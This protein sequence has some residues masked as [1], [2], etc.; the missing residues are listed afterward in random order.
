MRALLDIARVAAGALALSILS[1]AA[2]AQDRLFAGYAID[3]EGLH[4]GAFEAQLVTEPGR[5]QLS[6]AT[7]TEGLIGWLFPFV[8]EGW[9]RGT[10]TAGEIVPEHFQ[11]DSAWRDRTR[12]WAVAFDGDGQVVEI[13]VPEEDLQDRDPVPP[14]LQVAPDPL[15]LALD[16]IIS[17]A[18]GVQRTGT[19]FDGRRAIRFALDCAPTMEGFHDV[20]AGAAAAAEGEALACTVAGEL[21]AG[22]SR[23][24]RDRGDEEREPATVWLRGGILEGSLW[25]VRVVAETRYGTVTAQLVQ[26]ESGDPPP[27]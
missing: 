2:H 18:P 12:T 22:A 14:A 25:P 7:R 20:P 4:I 6:Y 19:S 26:L 23:R 3:W 8:A 1:Q 10:R 27:S 16:S 21:V 15:A 24:W 17:A 11:G 9:S 13:D 5:Y